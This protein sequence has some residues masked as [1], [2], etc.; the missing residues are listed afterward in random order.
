MAYSP[1]TGFL[2]CICGHTL[3]QWYK[4]FIKSSLI[5]ISIVWWA[6]RWQQRASAH[7]GQW[8]VMW[9]GME[10]CSRSWGALD[11]DPSLS[12][13]Y[14]LYTERQQ[15]RAY[16]AS[17]MYSMCNWN[18]V[19]PRLPWICRV[20]LAGSEGRVAQTWNFLPP[21]KMVCCVLWSTQPSDRYQSRK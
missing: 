2:R 19:S 16:Y 8:R 17:T 18:S 11:S 9:W 15:T 21:H 10:G 13:G 7:R 20:R 3:G 12:S 4:C 6:R 5:I 1:N 14:L